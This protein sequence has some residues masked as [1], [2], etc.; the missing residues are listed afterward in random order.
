MS[1]SDAFAVIA[2]TC[3]V[4]LIA[5]LATLLVL[6]A[7]TLRE[8]RAT[9]EN[10]RADAIALLDDTSAAVTDASREIE[11]VELLVTSAERLDE[12]KRTIASPAVKAMAFGT[13]VSRGARRF[14]NRPR[15][16]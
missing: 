14:R 8:L 13:G 3:V 15:A 7:R 4:I 5:V 2:A 10:F 12:V 9:I 11:R 16:S 6:F 1:A